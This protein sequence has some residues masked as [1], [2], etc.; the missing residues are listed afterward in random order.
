MSI[1]IAVDHGNHSIKSPNF[2]FPSGLVELPGKAT[3]HET[4]L[5]EF[6]GRIWA[7]SNE[8]LFYSR[9][10]TQTENFFILTLFAVAKELEHVG[11][12]GPLI[13]IALSVGLPP[14]HFSALKETFKAYFS[15]GYVDFA[16][17][18]RPI[19]IA[20]QH[21]FVFPQAFAAVAARAQTLL[22]TPQTFII[23]IGGYTTD[24]LLLRDGVPDLQFCHSL[25]TGTITMSNQII[26]QVNAKHDMRIEDGH[27]NAVLRHKKSGLPADVQ[28]LIHDAA[29]Q[30]ANN[31]INQLREL[32]VDLR[33]NPAT[34]IGGGALLFKAHLENSPLVMQAEFEADVRANAIGYKLLGARQLKKLKET[35]GSSGENR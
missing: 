6:E 35:G 29:E 31:L 21:V 11:I 8:R 4:D 25:E 27:I 34:F 10:K 1:L 26:G 32:R 3:I 24:I 9:D 20:I 7:L 15:R 16:Y 12:K 18:D 28:T 23:D 19:K 13:K 2:S 5:V 30:H 17:N 14:G 33:A 22:D